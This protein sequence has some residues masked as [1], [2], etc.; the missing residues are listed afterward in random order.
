MCFSLLKDAFFV[1]L[2]L[3]SRT[4]GDAE[5]DGLEPG[6]TQQ[7]IFSTKRDICWISAYERIKGR[8]RKKK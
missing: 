1:Y 6:Y 4:Y 2:A 5:D 7:D 8:R 3:Q